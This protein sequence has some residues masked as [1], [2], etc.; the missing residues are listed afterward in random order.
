MSLL[1]EGVRV[2]D[3]TN[4]ISGPLCSYQLGMLGAEVIKI[5]VPR[6]GDLARGMGCDSELIA[7]QMGD[8][9]CAINAGKKSITLNLKDDEGRRIF[10]AL[11]ET[12]DV[13]LENFRPGVMK[14]LGLDWETLKDINPGLVYCAISGFGQEG[15][16]AGRPSYDQIIQGFCGIMSVTGEKEGGPTRAGYV[17]CDTMAAVTGAFAICAALVKKGK[18]GRG[19]MIDVSMLDASLASMATWMISNLVNGGMAPARLGNHNPSGSPSGTFRTGDGMLNIATNEQKQFDALCDCLGLAEVKAAER[20]RGRENRIEHREELQLLVEGALASM[21]AREW[22]VIFSKAGVPAGPV[23]SISEALEHPQVRSRELMKRFDS[24]GGLDRPI[25][26]TR[27][28]FHLESGNPD[29]SSPPP[30]LGQDTARI[31]GALG[32]SPERLE[33]LAS[34]G[35]I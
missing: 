9:F 11:V 14:K 1:L 6:R 12:A 35:V 31:L 23:L 2:L 28:G 18:S 24:V 22:E 4:V 17:V 19:E 8:S 3:L 33:E 20:F 34:R 30:R 32:L 29:V 16:L 15:P 26:V 27:L 7:A 13:V 25:S 5:E 10:K 21:S